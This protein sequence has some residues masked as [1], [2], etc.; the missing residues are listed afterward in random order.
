MLLR[1]RLLAS[2][3][4]AIAIGLGSLD[5][6]RAYSHSDLSFKPAFRGQLGPPRPTAKTSEAGVTE[7]GPIA[8]VDGAF[9]QRGPFNSLWIRLGGDGRTKVGTGVL[10]KLVGDALTE[11]ASLKI[12]GAVYVAL[13]ER[14]V[15]PEHV[16][17]L[18][19]CGFRFHHHRKSPAPEGDEFVYYRWPDRPDYPDKVPPYSTATEGVGALALSPDEKRVLLVWEYG[20]WKMPT[21]AVDAGEGALQALRRELAEEVCCRLDQQFA[22]LYLGGWQVSRSFD[23]QMSN[24]FSVYAVRAAAEATTIDPNEVRHAPRL[25]GRP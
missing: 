19:A 25:L 6:C 5:G 2:G 13:D 9:L 14:S 8:L 17:C 20:C 21:G 11:Q 7:T 10:E 12:P 3:A 4:A 1:R 15:A 23:G 16:R 22:P 24:Q 18:H